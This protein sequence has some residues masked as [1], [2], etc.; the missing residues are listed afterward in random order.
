M[1]VTGGLSNRQNC[2]GCSDVKM[3]Y[4]PDLPYCQCGMYRKCHIGFLVMQCWW[5]LPDELPPAY[6]PASPHSPEILR[7]KRSCCP[8]GRPVVFC[9]SGWWEVG[10]KERITW[11]TA[12]MLIYC[13]SWCYIS[14]NCLRVEHFR[15]CIG[16][17]GHVWLRWV[18]LIWL[19]WIISF[20]FRSKHPNQ[21]APLPLSLYLSEPERS[22]EEYGHI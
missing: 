11:I 5:L 20:V 1:S 4:V 15:I 8:E 19:R 12:L 7:N 10:I 21:L 3:P 6:K 13:G 17:G 16:M 18:L 14:K 22:Q 2:W 9:H